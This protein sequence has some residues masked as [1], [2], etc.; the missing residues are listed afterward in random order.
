MKFGIYIQV[1]LRMNCNIFSFNLA[2]SSGQNLN[3]SNT[4]VY[5]HIPAKRK[6]KGTPRSQKSVA[7][8]LKIRE[9]CLCAQI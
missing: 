3:L 2:P 8:N 9:S 4:L 6:T 5:D 7:L 1:L